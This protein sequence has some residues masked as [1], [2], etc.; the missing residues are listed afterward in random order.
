MLSRLP[1]KLGSK[2][3]TILLLFF[4]VA[5]TMIILTLYVSR[6][7]EGGAAA[8]N[9]A[10]AQRMR[11][12]RIAYLLERA[13]EAPDR[14]PW[15]AEVG[16]AVELFHSALLLLDEGDPERPL[17][18]PRTEE[19]RQALAGLR[20]DWR[21]RLLPL[22]GRAMAAADGVEA[23]QRLDDLAEGVR[24][25]VPKI[26]AL[27][28]IVERTNARYTNLTW[29]I[30]NA[31]VG[32]AL[33]G[34]LFLIL[35]FRLV[36]IQPVETLKLGMDSMAADD[37]GV[38]VPVESGDEI[39]ELAAGFNRMADHLR[40]LYSTLE[41]RVADKTRDIEVK[42]RELAALYEIAAFL[43][44]PAGIE[45]L[46]HGVLEKLRALLSA[47]S[48]AIRL[49]DGKAS[50]LEIVASTGL[51]PEFLDA[52]AHLPIGTCLCG[53]TAQGGGPITQC[54]SGGEGLPANCER[55]GAS[56]MVAVPIKSKNQVFG[57]FNLF[58][59]QPRHLSGDEVQ[60]LETVGQ[61]LGVAIENQRLAVREKEMAVSEERNLL[62]QELH[63]SIAQS[64]AFLNIQA[65]MLDASLRDGAMT[66]AREELDRMREGVQESYDNVRELLVHFRIRVEDADL[67]EAIASALEKFEGQT[68]IATSL[69][70]IGDM[71]PPDAVSVI[72]ILH[73]VQEALSNVRKHAQA[74]AVSVA[75]RGGDEFTITV[76]DNGRGFDPA[77]VAEEGGSHVGV[78]IMRER[79]RRIGARFE[80]ESS[81]GQGACVTL[82]LPIS[83]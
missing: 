4:L 69:E 19:I 35:L 18:L 76:R 75:M 14:A 78:G 21:R 16:D 46:A 47:D 64:L 34:T 28:L 71:P 41:Q 17:F 72:Q 79:A 36:V 23:H 68:G 74:T 52:E 65:Q 20:Q 31:L 60:L 6:Q 10:G 55:I 70:R 38:R 67:D 63:D 27:V 8:I 73:I 12:Y 42:N 48:G 40:D 53:C 24:D 54:L 56:M 30:Q 62:A 2:I 83:T 49:I 3:N 51:S 39:G 61:H 59:G 57:V 82:V 11:T 77:T 9:E 1:V 13:A 58:F 7:L 37:F 45:T 50:T 44:K 32:F 5:L 43:A 81:A 80:L 29:L 22:I 15:L 33:V 26:N 25:F 66:A